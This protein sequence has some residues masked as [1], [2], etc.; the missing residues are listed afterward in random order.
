MSP[1]AKP[2]Q[3]EQAPRGSPG[4]LR[5]LKGRR[6]SQMAGCRDCGLRSTAV[7]DPGAGGGN[8]PSLDQ[9]ASALLVD[10]IVSARSILLPLPCEC[11]AE[12][13]FGVV[14]DRI[15]CAANDLTTAKLGL[16]SM[17]AHD[18]I[19]F[20]FHFLPCRAR[21]THVLVQL[22][23]RSSIPTDID[24]GMRGF[25]SVASRCRKNPTE[26]VVSGTFP[27]CRFR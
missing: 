3:Q 16:D 18:K 24:F 21:L 17:L 2:L 11:L 22:P 26:C 27:L 1:V 23:H 4:N 10:G 13:Q 9:I 25:A 15:V 20:P 6:K 14:T 5:R 19:S 8:S 12:Q 7:I